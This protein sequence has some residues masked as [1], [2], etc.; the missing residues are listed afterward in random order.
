M[1]NRRLSPTQII[2]CIVVGVLLL[3]NIVR[4]HSDTLVDPFSE[5]RNSPFSFTDVEVIPLTDGKIAIA[6]NLSSS[7]SVFFANVRFSVF[8]DSTRKEVIYTETYRIGEIAAGEEKPFSFII[9]ADKGSTSGDIYLA[10]TLGLTKLT[11]YS[12][13]IRFFGS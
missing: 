3:A 2:L 10:V 8:K 9:S 5:M 12:D 1:Q 7:K 13:E 4:N 6:G 11:A